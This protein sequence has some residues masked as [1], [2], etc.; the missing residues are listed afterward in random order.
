[1]YRKTTL[2]NIG[3]LITQ[4]CTFTER[5]KQECAISPLLFDICIDW[6]LQELNKTGHDIRGGPRSTRPRDSANCL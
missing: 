4:N 6:I 3:K 5:L 1:M 2:M